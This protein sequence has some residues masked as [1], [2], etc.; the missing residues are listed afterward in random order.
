MMVVKL[1]GFASKVSGS[2]LPDTLFQT[3]VRPNR[4][5][6]YNKVKVL[7]SLVLRRM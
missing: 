3:T 6:Q 7:H 1:A 4:F 5:V 2:L